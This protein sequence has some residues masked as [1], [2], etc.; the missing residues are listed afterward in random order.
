[1]AKQT[2]KSLRCS[3]VYSVYV[4]NHSAEGTFKALERDLGRIRSLGV[5][6]VDLSWLFAALY[7]IKQKEIMAR[8][9]CRLRAY[10]AEDIIAG[11]YTWAEQKL[12]GVF[13]LRGKQAGLPDGLY[14]NLI[15][16]SEV[17]VAGG[18]LFCAARPVIIGQ[19]IQEGIS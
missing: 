1:M 11:A 17:P 2:E 5:D 15:D 4:R 19:L 12:V 10:E 6:I 16:G 3:V 9:V 18:R 7:P 13:S 14:R 8:G